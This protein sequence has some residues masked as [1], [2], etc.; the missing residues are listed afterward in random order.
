MSS[1]EKRVYRFGDGVADGDGSMPDLLGGKGAGLAEMTLLGVPVPPGFT[2]TTKVCHHWLE[3]GANPTGLQLEI[4]TAVEWLESIVGRRLEDSANPLLVSVRS[5]APISM[6]G[7]M[8][9]ILNVGLNDACVEGLAEKS[10]SRR[11]ALDL[12]RRLIQMFGTIVL[13]VPKQEFDRA[14]E[15]VKRA[16]RFANDSELSESPLEKTIEAF[17]QLVLTRTGKPFPQE[18]REQLEMAVTAVFSSWNNERARCYRKLNH[19]PETLGTAVTVQAMV[20]GNRGEDSGTGV[21]FT[22]NPSTGE[23]NIFGEF[24]PNAQ[25]EDIVAGTRT[26]MPISKLAETMPHVYRELLAVTAMLENHYREMQDFEFTIESGKLFLLQTRTAKRAA[27]AV[28]RIAVEMASEGLISKTEAFNRVK[29]E[30]I[31]EVLSSQLDTSSHPAILT[32]GLAASPGSVVGQIALSANQAVTMVARGE[33]VVLVTEE[34]TAD[35]IHGMAVAPGFL[36]ARGGATSHAAVVARGMGKCCITGARDIEL[37]EKADAVQIGGKLFH[38]GDWLSLEGSTGRVF[39][40][41]LPVRAADNDHPH[42]DALLAWAKNTGAC[43]VRANADTPQDAAAARRMGAAGIGLCR[44][45]HMFFAADRLGHMRSMI[46]AKTKEERA[47]ALDRLLPIQQ[48]DFEELFRT[49]SPLPVTIRL[50]DPPLHEFLPSIDEINGEITSARRE[51]NWELAI[52]LEANRKQVETLRETNPMMGHRGCRLSLTCPEILEMQVR[53]ILQAALVVSA[54]GLNPAPEIMVPLIASEEEMKVL[55]E[56]IRKTAQQVFAAHG[57]EIPY[58][59]GAMIELPRA[60]ICADRIARHVSFLSFGTNDLTQMTYGFSR[61]DARTYL[62][63][64][65]QQGILKTDPFITIDR[66]GVGYLVELAVNSVRAVSPKIK[67]GVCGEHGGDPESI[68][69]F[70]SLGLDYVSCSPFRL[71]VAQLAAAQ[72]HL[73]EA[74]LPEEKTQPQMLLAREPNRNSQEELQLDTAA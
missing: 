18:P 13:E 5:G 41:K 60:A 31:A 22:R 40:G 26:P 70:S 58:T 51:E 74:R 64:Y 11:F 7:M 33:K 17:K 19:I 55:A 30:S 10:G 50:L 45:E 4:D 21:G 27:P 49:M 6:P 46:L 36:T 28:V 71:P 15:A 47:R 48:H 54:E 20:F 14:L 52:E 61:D 23:K 3:H 24:L 68:H 35:D 57:R 44:T 8:D 1:F 29:P 43:L 56:L 66:E 9:T 72:A 32:Q 38:S 53:A 69:F 59:I 37:D 67:I 62:D 34:T 65:L 16:H 42:L 39:E 2:I 73:S 12:Y 25:G 63:G